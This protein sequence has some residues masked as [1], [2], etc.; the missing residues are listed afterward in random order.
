MIKMEKT[1]VDQGKE[2]V[3]LQ[4]KVKTLMGKST[5]VQ[6]RALM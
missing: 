2:I 3:E 4:D 5:A 1:I 6:I